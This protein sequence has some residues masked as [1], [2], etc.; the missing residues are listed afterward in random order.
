[1][2]TP[3]SE[4]DF[5][6]DL[7][8]E[9]SEGWQA[10]REG[11]A[12]LGVNLRNQM[13]RA[14]RAELDYVLMPVGGPLPERD[15]PRR[16]FIQRQLP[17]PAPPLSLQ[18]LNRRLRA[19]ADADNVKGVVFIFQGF[20]A[21]LARLQNFRET[22]NRLRAA[23]KEVIVY[24]PRLDNAHYF[25]ATA[26]DRIIVPPSA[27]FEAFGLRSRVVFLKDTLAQ[28]GLQA[29][30][31]AI[32]PYK[33]AGD[34]LS[35]AEMPPAHREQLNWL[36]DELFETLA[37]GMAD[38]RSLSHTEMVDHLNHAPYTAAA[39]QERGLIDQIAYED[40]LAYLLAGPASESEEEPKSEKEG[41]ATAEEGN[42]ENGRPQARLEPWPD[43]A[44]LLLEKVR[45][46]TRRYVG[47]VSLEGTII[48]GESQQPPV[49]LPIPI[50]GGALAGEQTLTRLLRRAEADEQMAALIFHVDSGGGSALASDLIARQIRRLA[51]RKPV[52]VY[53]GDVAA[54]G[55]YYVSAPA[56]AIMCQTGTITGSIGVVMGRVAARGLYQKLQANP[57]HLDRGERV[58]LYRDDTPMTAEERAIFRQ[59]IAETYDEFKQVVAEGR[60]IPFQELDPIC[61]GRVWSGR[62]ALERGLVDGHGDFAA[63]VQRA[64]ELADLPGGDGRQVRVVNFHPERDGYRP[65]Q[66]FPDVTG[67]G[68]WLLSERWREVNGRPWL[69][70]PFHITL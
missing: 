13:R 34:R 22:V 10:I 1:M 27:R 64:A 55:G 31:V 36:L 53:M 23:G 57:V 19:V 52:L 33:T 30:I 60:E 18:T 66:P 70:I 2:D 20:E 59:S 7:K 61:E 39:A 43:A 5:F 56:A 24:T 8:R 6:S 4:P 49:D 69:L 58:G 40:E 17:L 16:S 44:P 12:A 35:E 47:V 67:I 63:A 26:A 32:S 38:G 29:D 21:G 50:V 28:I 9:L 45:R 11:W 48:M 15:E 46:P 65:P 25:A 62:Q 42:D 3:N 41:E 51:R 14:R 37:G 54:S 68:Q